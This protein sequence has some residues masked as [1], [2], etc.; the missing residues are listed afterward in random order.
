MGVG[1]GIGVGIAGEEGRAAVGINGDGREGDGREGDGREGDGREGEGRE[2]EGRG[3][4]E[5]RVEGDAPYGL[6]GCSFD[7]GEELLGVGEVGMIDESG[8]GDESEVVL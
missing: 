7:R 6:H 4:G 8:D 3:A 1:G 2:G 5:G